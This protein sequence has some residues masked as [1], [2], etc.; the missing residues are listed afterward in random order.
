MSLSSILFG[1]NKTSTHRSINVVIQHSLV[2]I[3][4]LLLPMLLTQSDSAYSIRMLNHI[5]ISIVM[6]LVVF[7]INYGVLVNRLAFRK[8]MM[9]F[10]L[11]NLVIFALLS[12]MSDP[13]HKLVSPPSTKNRP[14]MSLQNFSIY[15]IYFYREFIMYSLVTGVAI[16]IRNGR[17]LSTSESERKRLETENLRSQISL[18]KYQIQP[19]FFFNT[20][21]NIYALIGKSPNEAQQAVIRL[22]KMM[23]YVLY[24]NNTDSIP[25]DKE[26]E[27]LNHY[28]KLMQLRLTSNT[29]VDISYPSHISHI[30]VPPL[31]FVSLLENAYK[32]GVCNSEPSFIKN[33]LTITDSE[34]IFTT[35]NST[36]N[37]DRNEDKSKSG[38]GLMNMKKRLDI[39]YGNQYTLKLCEENGIFKSELTI[40]VKNS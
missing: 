17:R 7:Y 4:L 36:H 20:L 40:P 26:I 39:L 5:W 30:N 35:E 3:G 31:I 22:S 37:F 11:I 25:L 32:H 34:V 21:N 28:N 10:I 13:L 15:G 6:S 14:P 1:N 2:W 38:I 23:R 16:A 33:C 27:F 18:L 24:D 8:H 12:M 19:H 29:K 9:A